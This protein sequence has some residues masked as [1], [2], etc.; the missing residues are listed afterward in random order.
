MSYYN[1]K[2]GNNIH[3]QYYLLNNNLKIYFNNPKRYLNYLVKKLEKL[4]KN[5]LYIYHNLKDSDGYKYIKDKN[6]NDAIFLNGAKPYG[7]NSK[8]Y[9]LTKSS[10]DTK[11]TKFNN[12]SNESFEYISNKYIKYN[13]NIKFNEN[14]DIIIYLPNLIGF[15]RKYININ[16]LSNLIKFIR[17]KKNNRIVVRLHHK[18]HEKKY[19]KLI[20]KLVNN[21]DNIK[22]DLQ[23]IEWRDIFDNCCCVFIQNSTMIF[24]LLSYGIPIFNIEMILKLNLFPDLSIN[25][26]VLNDFKE[27]YSKLN[28]KE[29]LSKYYSSIC[30]ASESLEDQTDLILNFYKRNFN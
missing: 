9:F 3:N 17:E 29:L 18:N 30:F 10:I 16:K 8:F 24:I 14:G 11:N 26:N 4:I 13:E 12:I 6:N 28:R 20:K 27:E 22:V 7:C 2:K 21:F 1:I 23:K 19:I 5:D 25:L 15:Y